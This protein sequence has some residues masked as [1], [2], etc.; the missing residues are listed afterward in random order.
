MSQRGIQQ[1]NQLS[2]QAKTYW[3]GISARER[4]LI[5]IAAPLLLAWI[6]W[7]GIVQPV[8][9]KHDQAQQEVLNNQQMLNRVKGTAAEILRLQAKGAVITERPNGPLD[10]LI[11][12]SAS[13]YGLRVTGVRTQQ[14]RLQVSLA[15]A[16]FDQLMGWLVELE[17]GSSVV[18]EQLRIEQTQ[19][20]GIV[21][22]ER[23]ELSEG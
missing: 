11:N 10:Q 14:N 1:L 2:Q 12:R 23:L 17:K 7:M 16:S 3:S 18:I 6:V 5:T 8:L 22:I 13:E 19:L 20:P 15:N 9:N 21:S 4:Q